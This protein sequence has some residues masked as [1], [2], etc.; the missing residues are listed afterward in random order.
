MLELTYLALNSEI[1][2]TNEIQYTKPVV[3]EKSSS[4]L[5]KGGLFNTKT[6][7]RFEI[8]KKLPQVAN[9]FDAMFDYADAYGNIRVAYIDSAHEIGPTP[10]FVKKASA[11]GGVLGI[12]TA[13]YNGFA[14]HIA[15][16]ISQS[17]SA[18]NPDKNN[19]NEDFFNTDKDSFAYIAEA[20]INYTL[21]NFH[22]MMGRIKIETPYADSDDIRMAAN[23]FEGAW[24][25]VD[26]SEN[27]NT[28]F[29]F[30]NR[31]AGYD[32]QDEAAGLSQDRFKPLVDEQSFGMLLASLTYGYAPESEL[33]FWYNYVDGMSAVTYMEAVGLYSIDENM[34]IDYG[35]QWSH[36]QELE[37]SHVAGDVLGGML[38]GHCHGFYVGGAYNIAMVDDGDFIS[39]G[40]GGGPYYTSLD[41]AT[42]E[43]MSVAMKET[44]EAYRIGSGYTFSNGNLEG[45][46]IELVYGKM[47]HE[48]V[49]IIERDVLLT[50]EGTKG[51]SAEAVYTTF[52][53]TT[54]NE[55]NTF[56]RYHFK[57][58]YSF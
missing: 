6:A 3:L 32:S 47:Y 58:D 11:I 8:V 15:T 54:T 49:S 44:S 17:I 30:L 53:D 23:T 20:N 1:Q 51:W 31:W 22:S 19:I 38:I 13:A 43:A 55:Y 12:N 36:F 16:Y 2:Y 46:N 33:S 52:H 48:D 40:F 5:P 21:N 34:H 27:L 18:I 57:I 29:A 25:E 10:K 45:L 4:E 26:I 7:G 9:S 41:E 14:A 28:Q 35:L 24:A 37:S 50:Y 42:I 39:N 56:N